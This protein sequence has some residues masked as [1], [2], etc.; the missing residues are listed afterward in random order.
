MNKQLSYKASLTM[1][2][3]A[4]IGITLVLLWIRFWWRTPKRDFTVWNKTYLEQ[5]W[6]LEAWS[7][8]NITG[9]L[10]IGPYKDLWTQRY[11]FLEWR[12]ILV[13]G[14]PIWTTIWSPMW[15]Q[16]WN[17]DA[18]AT[19]VS[20]PP[21]HFSFRLYNY[22]YEDAKRW[23]HELWSKQVPIQ[24]II[25]N[26]QFWQDGSQFA[27]LQDI[28]RDNASV[29]II[30][31]DRLGLNYQHAK[32]FLTDTRFIIQTANMTYSSFRNSR[33]IFFL[34]E[35]KDILQSLQHLFQNDRAWRKTDK[36]ELHP[37][38]V[39]C[40]INCR[41]HIET[42]LESAESSIYMYQQYVQDKSIQNI[43]VRK[44]DA[45]VDI[46]LILGNDPNEKNTNDENAGDKSR[47]WPT[48]PN[49][50]Q[51]TILVQSSPYV[52]AKA[53][54]VDNQ[55]LL[56]G[57][58]NISANSL[59]NNREIWILLLNDELI[60]KFQNMFLKDWKKKQ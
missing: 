21:K 24:W 31:D 25:E 54:L 52:H 18:S 29:H 17:I 46:K 34:S 32:T 9:D 36:S 10:L 22:T 49:T 51:D 27:Q 40:P 60:R 42:L 8:Q 5:Q 1:S 15:K 11:S 12:K 58:M 19:M 55:F 6:K 26:R 56:I 47:N 37:N 28:F 30:W 16:N 50:L 7:L 14:T 48:M 59:D 43:L 33:E 38:L 57:S 53:I 23:M 45:W 20:N 35:N 41:Q 13:W 39:V 44:K 3:I 2:I 4:I